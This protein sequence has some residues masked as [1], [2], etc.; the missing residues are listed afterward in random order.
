MPSASVAI[1]PD[2]PF[3]PTRW[4]AKTA[5]TQTNFS[6]ISVG[7]RDDGEVV[8]ELG[9]RGVIVRGGTPLGGPGHI[10]VTYGTAEENAK[11][12]EALRAIL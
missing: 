10:R 2:R 9:K 5:A 7:E 12:L 6:W 4:F 3:V 11:F 8:E 1:A